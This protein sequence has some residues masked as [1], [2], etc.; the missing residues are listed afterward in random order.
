MTNFS[1]TLGYGLE[2][3]ALI[4]MEND[5]SKMETCREALF[6]GI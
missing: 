4:Y 2:D 5:D 6:E 3:Q 1:S